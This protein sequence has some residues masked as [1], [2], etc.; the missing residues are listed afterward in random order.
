MGCNDTPKFGGGTYWDG[1]LE[2]HRDF[3][4]LQNTQNKMP[5]V[6]QVREKIR[7]DIIKKLKQLATGNNKKSI[8]TFLDGNNVNAALQDSEI[9]SL[10]EFYRSVHAEVAAIT[11][12]AYNG[13]AIKGQKLYCTTFPCHLCCKAIISGGLKEVFYIEPYPKSRSKYFYEDMIV[14]KPDNK[15]IEKNKVIFNSYRGVSPTN[16]TRFFMAKNKYERIVS[17]KI[18]KFDVNTKSIPA[19]LKTRTPSHYA[20]SEKYVLKLW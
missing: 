2:D 5:Y 8:I 7:E 20:Y 13:I 18:N 3:A 14:D 12:A 6:D 1:D 9:K 11:A 16:Y 4:V 17:D 19:L 10:L 15:E